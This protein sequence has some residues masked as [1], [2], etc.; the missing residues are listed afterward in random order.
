MHSIQAKTTILTVTAIFVAMFVA[1]LIGAISIVN[2]GSN[3]AEHML[4][5]LCEAGQKS[6]DY[7]FDSIEKSVDMVSSYITGDLSM[8]EIEDLDQH[9]DKARSFFNTTAAKTNGVLTYYYRL[10]PTLETEEKGFWYVNLDDNGFVEHEVTDISDDQFECVWFY[11]PKALGKAIWLPPYQTDNLD[12]YVLSYNVPVYKGSTFIGVV[13]IELD[14]TTMKN[15]VD[16]ITLYKT[17]YAFVNDD[18]GNIVYHPH[19]DV[20]EE[21]APET[22]AGLLSSNH[23]V[24]YI[25][26][27]K[28][29]EAVW[30]ELKNGMRINVTIEVSE[31][32]GGW[33][34]LVIYV[35]IAGVA[36]MIVF[37]TLTFVFSRHFTKP[38]RELTNAAEEI[39]RGNYNV[40][41]DYKGKDEISVLTATVNKLIDHLRGY[42]T[43]L[44][45]LAYAD[46]LTSVRN[47]SAF[48][49]FAKELQKKIDNGDASLKFA[50]CMLDCDD[51]K[52][53]NDRY[54]HD[55]GDVYLKNSSHLICRVF[56]KSPVFRI[57]GDE[58]IAILQGSDYQNR[59]ELRKL[60]IEKSA[61]ICSFASE[62][63]ECI[64]VAIGIA[65]YNS[66]TDT[67]VDEVVQRADHLMYYN[68][69]ERKKPI[70]PNKIE[71]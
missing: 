8:T 63:W 66:S 24:K 68:K 60:F 50:I 5:L 14:Y 25:Y 15:Q 45:S 37:V 49:L 67:N 9:M 44:N 2:I 38:L 1:T 57:G 26:E 48:D 22:P 3:N 11:E 21:E 71:K 4:E 20:L 42:I 46:S 16:M 32:N 27:G 6:L 7:Y 35:V 39:N 18:E 64:R 47:K 33:T 31:I 23:F 56:S 43:D 29:K 34:N 51:L 53:I 40:K 12:V 41:L 70:K 52:V 19:F 59:K 30:L 65:D 28:A 55:K 13:G 54:G 36:I 17:G 61:E 62:P 69:S 10:D 58:F